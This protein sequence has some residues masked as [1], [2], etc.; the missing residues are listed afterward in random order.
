MKYIQTIVTAH[1][2]YNPTF[3]R[4]N[5]E[6]CGPGLKPAGPLSIALSGARKAEGRRR[7]AGKLITSSLALSSPYCLVCP[8]LDV[9]FL[10]SYHSLSW[11]RLQWVI[12]MFPTGRVSFLLLLLP[13]P[14]LP[15]CAPGFCG[16]MYLLLVRLLLDFV[17][18]HDDWRMLFEFKPDVH[19]TMV[20]L[21]TRMLL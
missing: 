19:C 17:I 5:G 21:S 15:S 2:Y 3:Y 10:E 8:G 4:H 9:A 16:S 13:V 20:P 7:R 12:V 14:Q 6:K 18:K 11:L 1:I